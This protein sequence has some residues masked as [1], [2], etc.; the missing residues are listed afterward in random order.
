PAALQHGIAAAAQIGELAADAVEVGGVEDDGR[1]GTDPI[2]ALAAEQAVERQPSNAP[3][4]VPE[5]HIDGAE[6]EGDDAAVAGPVGGLA[7]LR[8]NRL[9]VLRIA[10]DQPVAKA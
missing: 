5:R 7:E 1:R 2:T 8:P 6:G 3:G 4:D 9:D 10:A